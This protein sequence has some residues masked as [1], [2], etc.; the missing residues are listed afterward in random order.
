MICCVGLA[1]Q[2]GSAVSYWEEQAA[3]QVL[4]CTVTALGLVRLVMQ[5]KVMAAS[6]A[7]SLSS[8]VWCSAW[9]SASTI[10]EGWAG[11]SMRPVQNRD[12]PLSAPLT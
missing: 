8:E 6:G 10:N 11:L 9:R 4:F 12:I 5:P 7:A 1:V 2:L 3:Q